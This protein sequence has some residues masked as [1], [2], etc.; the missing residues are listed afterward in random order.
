MKTLLI[1]NPIILLALLETSKHLTEEMQ[2]TKLMMI[3]ASSYKS[4]R[5]GQRPMSENISQDT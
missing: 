5:G 2:N 3:Y 4:K 1:S